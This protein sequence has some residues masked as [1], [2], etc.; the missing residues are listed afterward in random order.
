M[1]GKRALGELLTITPF[2]NV[3]DFVSALTHTLREEPQYLPA[4][5]KNLREKIE[6]MRP[7]TANQ[8]VA[9]DS[10]ASC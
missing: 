9:A 5:L 7:A 1:D 3:A 6:A 8:F 4:G 2:R 10:A